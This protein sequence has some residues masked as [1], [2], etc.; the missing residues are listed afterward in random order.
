MTNVTSVVDGFFTV[1]NKDFTDTLSSTVLSGATTIPVNSA[2]E[3]SDG[4]F[5]VWVIA[6]DTANQVAVHGE[7]SGDSIINAVWTDGTAAA[8]YAAGTTVVDWVTATNQALINKGLKVEHN[9]DGT[10]SNITATS[11]STTG[12][13]DVDGNADVAGTLDVTGATNLK[14]TVS[15]NSVNVNTIR[16]ELL[17]Y[18]F[19]SSGGTIASV[20]GL[21]GSFSNIVAYIGGKRVTAT[22]VANKAYTASK[23]T[24]VDMDNTGA[25][26]YNEVANGA[27]SPSLAAN[28]VRVGVVVTG[29][30][31]ISTIRQRGW[32][33]LGNKV[34]RRANEMNLLGGITLMTT[35]DSLSVTPVSARRYLKVYYR[36]INS[37]TI[38][39]VLRF[40]NDSGNNYAWRQNSNDAAASTATSTSG[41]TVASSAAVDYSGYID[42]NNRQTSE[43]HVINHQ[44]N[45]TA[46]AGNA[47]NRQQ[48]VGKW[49]NTSDSVT[50]VDIVQTDTGDYVAGSEIEVIGWD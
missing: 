9:D 16:S 44:L 24:Y 42:V 12:N 32:D 8:S 26:S 19:V 20:S 17:P 11:I 37:G 27:A 1:A 10:H 39:G 40:N 15:E 13:A 7:I 46:G 25:I 14:G 6:P 35:A 29:G 23:D 45:S 2:A 28:S 3:Y 34:Y 31:A 48:T 49:A 50:R 30:A 41:I 4:D 47:T 43:K 33:T 38:N 36:L 18:D 5:V 22:S 21:T